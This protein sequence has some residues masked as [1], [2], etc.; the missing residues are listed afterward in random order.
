MTKHPIRKFFGL[1]ALYLVIIL[2]IF[3]LQFSKDQRITRA[4]GSLHFTL[5]EAKKG[6]SASKSALTLAYQ[7]ITISASE[8][9]PALL[10]FSDGRSVPLT[11]ESWQQISGNSVEFTFSNEVSLRITNTESEQALLFDAAMPGNASAVSFEYS[12]NKGYTI[13]EQTAERTIFG[14][15][16][17]M[18]VLSAP[19]HDGDTARDRLILYVGEHAVSYRPVNSESSLSFESIAGLEFAGDDRYRTTLNTITERLVA[20]YESG[21]QAANEQATVAYIAAMSAYG[22]RTQ[23]LSRIPASFSNST[24]R[25]YLSTPYFD[26]L[27]QA[28]WSIA[29][30]NTAFASRLD[31]AILNRDIDFFKTYGLGDYLIRERRA[32]QVTAFLQLPTAINFRP[33]TTQAAGIINVYSTLYPVRSLQAALLEP[34]IAVC[35]ETIVDSASLD[36]GQLTVSEEEYPLGLMQSVG[37]GAALINYGSVTRSPV[38]INVGQLIIDSVCIG[39]ETEFDLAT[40]SELYR[41]LNKNNT[42]YPRYVLLADRPE[43]PV[44]AWTVATSISYQLDAMQNITLTIDYPVGEIHHLIINGIPAFMSIDIYNMPYRSDPRFETYNS[45]GYVY[46]AET[47]T[48]LLKSMHRAQMESIRLL[49]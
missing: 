40:L 19:R 13:T 15:K 39:H 22:R 2:G 26:S 30:E 11:L 7:G 31:T 33:T 41:Q 20:A 27:V 18:F 12:P 48:L 46:D 14:S 17:D 23:A 28:N 45:S 21:P 16:T 38:Y 36:G 4:I 5:V 6:D 44:W 34:V 29:A 35:L 42:F 9:A 32:G 43:G 47:Q 24:A 25:T 37:I 3:I 10:F 8:N 1:I 49:Y